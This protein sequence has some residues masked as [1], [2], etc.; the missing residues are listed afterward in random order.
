MKKKRQANNQWQIGSSKQR[1]K[2]EGTLGAVIVQQEKGHRTCVCVKHR[3]DAN[4]WN[5]HSESLSLISRCRHARTVNR[6]GKGMGGG[7]ESGVQG[8]PRTLAAAAV[9][10]AAAAATPSPSFSNSPS[11][12]TDS[13]PP[14]PPPPLSLP[15]QPS[16]ASSFLFFFLVSCVDHSSV[17]ILLTTHYVNVGKLQG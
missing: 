9:V 6:G 2:V 10:A 16:G 13:N 17:S 1:N 12:P 11:H 3:E 14:P 7:G 5:K 4:A 8:R 15:F